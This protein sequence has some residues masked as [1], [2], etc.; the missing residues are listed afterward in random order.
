MVLTPAEDPRESHDHPGKDSIVGISMIPPET[1]LQALRLYCCSVT[2][3]YPTLCNPMNCR[4]P[5]FPVLHSFP[6]FAQIHVSW[7][8]GA[9]IYL[10]LC[11]PLLL[12]PSQSFR[13][14]GSFQMSQLL[15]SGGQSIE[16]SASAS[17]LPMNIQGWLPLGWTG[18]ISLQS[19]GPSRV[20]SNT[21]IWKHQFVGAQLS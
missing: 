7:V 8:G 19:K 10:I 5:G 17:V 18:W 11:R 3:L 6:E 9:S 13:A 16:V 14:S 20:F 12:L 1:T 2:K 4:M 15:A 21:T